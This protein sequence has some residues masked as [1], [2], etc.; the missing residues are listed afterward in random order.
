MKAGAGV[1]EK[2]KLYLFKD[3]SDY[4]SGDGSLD[5][6]TFGSNAT[7][8]YYGDDGNG[9]GRLAGKITDV[10]IV[11]GGYWGRKTPSI[12]TYF[13]IQDGN[14]G[15]WLPTTWIGTTGLN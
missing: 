15:G 4:D 9:I 8:F 7:N 3:W 13:W 6:G 10:K 11:I 12:F 1:Y 14:G 5:Y 2:G